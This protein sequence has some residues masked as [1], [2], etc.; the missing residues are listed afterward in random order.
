MFTGLD[1]GFWFWISWYVHKLTQLIQ[2]RNM[3]TM[4]ILG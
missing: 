4:C 3:A 2:T 1:N